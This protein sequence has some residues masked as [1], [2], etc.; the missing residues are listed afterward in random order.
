MEVRD[1]PAIDVH[2][3]YGRYNRDG[4]DALVSGFMSGDAA[5]VAERARGANIQ[6]TVVSPLLGLFPRGGADAAKGNDEAADIVPKTPGLRQWVIVDPQNP[7]TYDQARAMLQQPHC[8]GIKIHPEEH[9][10]PIVEHGEA[11][12]AFAAEHRAVVLTHSGEENS[13]PIDFIPFANAHPEMKVILAHLGNSGGGPVARYLQ[14]EAIQASKQGNVYTDTS[15][16]QS[17]LPGLIEYGVKELG[18][19]RILFGT[20]TPLYY[21][22][23]QR[24]RIENAEISDDDKRL[25]LRDNALALLD[26]PESD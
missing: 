16:S 4:F 14:V 10:Y 17:I 24:A 25:I 1:I 6:W 26:I 7:A 19:E 2:A 15:S 23:M 9:C 8:V 18:A 5:T 13:M 20:D 12:F 22:P 21:S 11:I 3:H